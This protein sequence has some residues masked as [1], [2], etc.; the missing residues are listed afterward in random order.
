MKLPTK[1]GV[2]TVNIRYH[3]TIVRPTVFTLI[4][5]DDLK[6]LEL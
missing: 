3:S 2:F 6:G 5:L 4:V 1:L